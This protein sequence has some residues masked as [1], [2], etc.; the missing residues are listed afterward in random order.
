M[1]N[2]KGEMQKFTVPADLKG[3]VDQKK[4]I[5]RSLNI[6]KMARP[7]RDN[8]FNISYTK[9]LSESIDVGD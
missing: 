4:M 7:D 5:R 6:S 8:K 1:A 2:T 3:I 9:K